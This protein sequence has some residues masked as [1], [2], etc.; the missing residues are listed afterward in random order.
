MS[1]VERIFTCQG[2]TPVEPS[3]PPRRLRPAF[4]GLL[5]ALT[6]LGHTLPSTAASLPPGSVPCATGPSPAGYGRFLLHKQANHTQSGTNAPAAT[7]ELAR[8]DLL[9]PS[10]YS[11]SNAVV[12]GPGGFRATLGRAADGSSSWTDSGAPG[13]FLPKLAAGAWSTSFLLGFTNGDSFIGFFP[14][15]LASNP[16]P[17]PA[18]ANL[19]AAQTID[20]RTA[21]TLSWNPWIGSGTNDRVQLVIVDGSGR[22]VVS[23][24]SDCSGVLPL[25]TGATSLEI[26]AGTLLAN[27]AYTG[28]LTFAASLLAT[29]D[30][31]T[32]VVE[33]A[34]E[35]RTT[36][37]ALKTAPASTGGSPGTFLN[38][39]LSG[40]NLVFTLRGQAGDIHR[41]ESTTGF[42]SWTKELDVTIPATGSVA[43]TI[44][45]PSDGVPRFY[46]AVAESGGTPVAD[47]ATL[48]IQVHSPG[49]LD[50]TVRGSPG[51]LYDVQRTVDGTNWVTVGTAVIPADGAPQVV[52]VTVPAGADYLLVRAVN[53]VVTP[54]APPRAPTLSI[55]PATFG[56]GG[57][58]FGAVRVLLTDG[59]PR[60]SYSLQQQALN[61]S[62]SPWITLSQGIS[63]DAN[64]S[65]SV[66]IG[67]AFIQPGTNLTPS[68]GFMIRAF[69]R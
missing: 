2:R 32:L 66:L 31:S 35:S 40:T 48:A 33:R 10:L 26:A 29:Q 8:I 39:T 20:A 4:V 16:P 30:D 49:E 11:I 5:T 6:V 67:R 18:I 36:T 34:Y 27:T 21:F 9:P 61:A 63:T 1:R 23:A 14:F 13:V 52:Y 41:I 46:R 68:T 43:V 59:S 57:G 12:S 42:V 55:A 37:F 22:T 54:P 44:P 62:E 64:G 56:G 3:T 25:A 69:A 60:K 58:G 47:P 45:L 50:I 51:G 65:G 24:A 19:P 7:E 28:H 17:V 38:P 15:L 53:R